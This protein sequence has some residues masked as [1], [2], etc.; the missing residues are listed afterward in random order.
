MTTLKTLM[1]R[2]LLISLAL[3]LFG[4]SSSS[5]DDDTTPDD[6]VS[7]VGTNE[8]NGNTTTNNTVTGN[9]NG[10]GS[11][12]NITS[13]TNQ[14]NIDV[15]SYSTSLIR[16]NYPSDWIV[17][18]SN[19]ALDAQ[20]LSSAFGGSNCGVG[21]T[22]A[23][24]GSLLELTEAFVDLFDAQPIPDVSFVTVNGTSMSRVSGQI[25]SAGTDGAAQLAYEDSYVHI[26]FCVG[27]TPDEL[28]VF[29][30]SMEIL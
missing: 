27:L 5:D 8:A 6:S 30:D 17:D 25:A 18:T 28:N 11:S 29:F 24:G 2:T 3:T 26:L 13:N 15:T 21:S 4:C 10:A 22:F 16:L 1:L 12:D 19:D 14:S 9:T 7:Q 23:P 20:F